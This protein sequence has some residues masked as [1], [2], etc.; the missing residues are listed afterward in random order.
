MQGQEGNSV[1]ASVPAGK[2]VPNL[3][4]FVADTARLVLLGTGAVI[5]ASKDQKERVKPDHFKLGVV[6]LAQGH[7]P[8]KDQKPDATTVLGQCTVVNAQCKHV[9]V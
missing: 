4:V 9:L 5:Q 1:A 7:Y 2:A 3:G 8:S 6:L